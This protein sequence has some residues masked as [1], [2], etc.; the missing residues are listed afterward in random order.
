MGKGW[1]NP[2]KV[3]TAAKKG[4]LFTKLAREV[5]VAARMGGPDPSYNSRLALAIE[6]A[7]SQSCPKDTIERAIRKGAGLDGDA[8]QI[9]ETMYEGFGPYNVGILVEC[10]TDNKNRTVTEI[11]NIFKKNG[12]SMGESGSV[13]WM[14]ERVGLIEGT[15]AEVKDP[16]EEA[17]EVGANEVEKN[18]DEGYSFYGSPEDLEQLRV[19]LTD[20][21]WTI[22]TA[23]LSYKPK[24]ITDLTAEQLEE[25]TKLLEALDDNEDSHRIHATIK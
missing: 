12:G 24:N 18:D 4:A 19:S 15:I 10:Q 17:I 25:V 16:E 7:R 23:E 5:A 9:D 6:S 20:R 3:A 8:S 13:S 1:K 2:H 14:F 22:Q 21:G 11:R